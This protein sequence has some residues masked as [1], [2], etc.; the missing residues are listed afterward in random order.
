MLTI[1]EINYIYIQ[2]FCK[3]FVAKYYLFNLRVDKSLS[4]ALQ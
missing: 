4:S 1:D 2:N 3:L